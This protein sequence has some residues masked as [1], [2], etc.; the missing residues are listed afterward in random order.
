MSAASDETR[1]AALPYRPDIDGLRALSVLAVVLYHFRVPYF[2]GGYVGVDVFFVISGYLITGIVLAEVT[3][4]T[5]SFARFYERRARRLLPT[6]TIVLLA[7]FLAGFAVMTPQDLKLLSK[8]TAHTVIFAANLFF[9]SQGGYFGPNLE[10]APL[11]HMWSLAVEEQFYIAWP[12][13]LMLA[14][15]YAPKRLLAIAAVLL[16]V[17]FYANVALIDTKPSAVFYRPQTR[18]WELLAGCILAF[19]VPKVRDVAAHVA[20]LA[21]LALVLFAIFAFTDETQ[22][23][24]VA[25]VVPVTGAALLIWS[26]QSAPSL[27]GRILS[28]RPLVFVGL[29]SYAWYLWHWPMV[30]LF[31]YQFERDPDA[32]EISILIVASFVLAALC[33]RFVESPIRHGRWWRIGPRTAVAAVTVSLATAGL[34]GTGVAT[35]GFIG[36]YPPIMRELARK[37]LSE[38]PQD[39]PCATEAM[40][41]GVSRGFCHLWD[42]KGEGPAILLWG[43]SHARSLRTVFRDLGEESDVSV[44]FSGASACPPLL[45]VSRVRSLGS[46]DR[47]RVANDAVGRALK[48]TRYRDVVLVARWGRYA[49]R[50]DVSNNQ[51]YIRDE[52]SRVSSIEENQRVIRESLRRTVEEIRA[53]GARAWIV[54]EAPYVDFDPPNRLA[55]LI[56]RGEHPQTMYGIDVVKERERNAFMRALVAELPVRVIDPAN[57]LCDAQR[58]LAVAHGKPLY[59]DDNHLSIYGAARLAPLMA[60][61]FSKRPV[62]A[63]SPADSRS[64]AVGPAQVPSRSPSIGTER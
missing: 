32:A 5:F 23:P 64:L 28:M 43:D 30:A 9:D 38:R 24:G 17:S 16:L 8:S 45:G 47:C 61:I 20:S 39:T 37:P 58:C 35:G 48:M 33:W 1:I 21:G 56:A 27:V 10:L 7:T 19:G 57:A 54:M 26:G 46:R 62:E 14:V 42:A 2:G 63:G 52:K 49:L 59:F 55:R 22:F 41:T 51:F 29:I 34:A 40:R 12:L 25:A 36:R 13:L 11:L 53:G 4:G 44:S 15:R 60:Q 6:L 50:S 18:A 31:R 3:S